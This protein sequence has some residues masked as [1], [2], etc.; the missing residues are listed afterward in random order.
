MN[1]KVVRFDVEP[2]AWYEPEVGRA[3]WALQNCR[4]RTLTM[5]EGLPQAVLHD[6]PSA[7]RNTIATVLYHIADAE[8]WWVYEH[9][10]QQPYP[11]DLAAR[12]PEEDRDE[13]GNLISPPGESLE[14]HLNRLS[15][16]R[17]LVLEAFQDATVEDFRQIHAVEEPRGITES[18]GGAILNHLGQHEAEH[19][20]EM[21]MIIQSVREQEESAGLVVQA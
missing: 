17:E 20:G 1:K 19:R 13:E 6:A 16:V 9:Y 3:I 18:S 14:A 15:Y 10:L 2:P 21:G 4:S 5:L 11:P 8:A 7:G 12:F